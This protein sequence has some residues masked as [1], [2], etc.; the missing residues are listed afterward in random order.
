VRHE[1]I[2]AIEES[3]VSDFDR[4]LCHTVDSVEAK[5]I[6]SRAME[7]RARKTVCA[8]L[9]DHPEWSK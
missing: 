1:L 4:G 8:I 3:A 2:K 5:L 7:V 6:Y 9:D